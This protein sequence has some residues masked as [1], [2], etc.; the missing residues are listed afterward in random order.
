MQAAPG[1]RRTA[2][3]RAGLRQRGIDL[4][5]VGAVRL[6]VIP[7]TCACPVREWLR[8]LQKGNLSKS[9]VDFLRASARR[10]GGRTAL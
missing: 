2:S 1:I 3:L 4:L 8:G 9:D 6:K 5:C 7:Y 10:T